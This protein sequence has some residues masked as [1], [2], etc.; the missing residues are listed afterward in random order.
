MS[1]KKNLLKKAK[2][3]CFFESMS[4]FLHCLKCDYFHK[5][6]MAVEKVFSDTFHILD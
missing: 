2:N 6:S 4:P 1:K 3:Y 5:C